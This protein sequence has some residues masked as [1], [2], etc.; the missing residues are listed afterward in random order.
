MNHEIITCDVCN[1][2]D[3][4]QGI[5]RLPHPNEGRGIFKGPRSAAAAAGWQFN[6]LP[7]NKGW[8]SWDGQDICPECQ[9]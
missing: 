5:V 4:T 6:R 2:Q 1:P 7:N 8:L 9:E 3:G